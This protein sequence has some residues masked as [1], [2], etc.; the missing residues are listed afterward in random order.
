MKFNNIQQNNS[1]KNSK[2]NS[3]YLGFNNEYQDNK[4]NKNNNTNSDVDGKYSTNN[5]SNEIKNNAEIGKISDEL[6]YFKRANKDLEDKLEAIR[7]SYNNKVDQ[8]EV[9]KISFSSKNTPFY[10][11]NYSKDKEIDSLRTKNSQFSNDNNYLKNNNNYRIEDQINNSLNNIENFKRFKEINKYKGN[12]NEKNSMTCE[13]WINTNNQNLNQ[14]T[15]S[16]QI[17]SGKAIINK[18]NNE[19]RDNQFNKQDLGSENYNFNY[20][21]NKN[22]YCNKL[23]DM[24]YSDN[25]EGK[26]DY[27]NYNSHINHHQ[28]NSNRN[29]YNMNFNNKMNLG[30]NY[31]EFKNHELNQDSIKNLHN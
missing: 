17:T 14:S 7:N 5:L 11:Y 13:D 25:I 24:Y 8:H 27:N 10:N 3:N 18:K 6:E 12:E 31:A 29:T 15:I 16:N 28:E 20:F 22:P 21:N 30:N 4:K 19:E 2:S 9:T 26:Y 23:S 1:Y